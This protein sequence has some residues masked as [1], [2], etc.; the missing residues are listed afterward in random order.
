MKV[1]V[2][3][4]SRLEEVT[5]QANLERE[6]P[7]GALV[8]DLLAQLFADFPRLREWDAHLLIAVR[9]EYADRTAPLRAGDAVAIMPPVQ[10]G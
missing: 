7:E 1:H 5:G 9:L 6:L 3:F 8:R 2:Q 10:G 4:F